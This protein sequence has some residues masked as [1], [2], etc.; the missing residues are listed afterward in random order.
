MDIKDAVHAI[1]DNI[2]NN[3]LHT[4]H[5]GII[6]LTVSIHL[7][8]PCNWYTD[9]IEACFCHHLHQLWLCNRL[10]PTGFMLLCCSP[11]LGSIV[12][13]KGITQIPAYAHVR[14]GVFSFLK[15]ACLCAH[16]H[17]QSTNKK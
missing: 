3:F 6:N 15:I 5:P 10:S 9:R 17:Q 16:A 14:Y 2:I 7:L 12:G 11:G 1:V 8:I 13:I 4:F